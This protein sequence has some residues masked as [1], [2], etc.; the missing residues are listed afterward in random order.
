MSLGR[1][2]LS[3]DSH[4][5]LKH[6]PT[7]GCAD[8][9]GPAVAALTNT[10]CHP[11]HQ[12]GQGAQ[13]EPGERLTDRCCL[14]TLELTFDEHL[15]PQLLSACQFNSINIVFISSRHTSLIYAAIILI[16][17]ITE[18]AVVSFKTLMM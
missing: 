7:C 12:T 15:Y 8:L 9:V 13:E 10:A 17:A 4:P 1:Y 6:D 16:A 3:D 5:Q 2:F 14:I 11:E 18:A